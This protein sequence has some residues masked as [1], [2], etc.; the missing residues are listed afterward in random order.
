M[1]FW[2]IL[3]VT[4]DQIAGVL[5]VSLRHPVDRTPLLFAEPSESRLRDGI[6]HPLPIEHVR[7]QV[8]DAVSAFDGVEERAHIFVGLHYRPPSMQIPPRIEFAKIIYITG[9]V[10]S[11]NWARVCLS[12]A[13]Q[14]SCGAVT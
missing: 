5:L 9:S 10:M 4:L 6:T 14:E 3:Q 12:M 1:E 13:S 7:V 8:D 11:S 2:S